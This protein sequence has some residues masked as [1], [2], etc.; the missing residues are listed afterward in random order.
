M[1]ATVYKQQHNSRSQTR[2]I[3][4][5]MREFERQRTMYA[6]SRAVRENTGNEG[7]TSG[8]HQS[9]QPVQTVQYTQLFRYGRC[10][11]GHGPS[12]SVV[13]MRSHNSIPS[14]DGSMKA[15]ESLESKFR[16][17]HT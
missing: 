13:R 3:Q 15:G 1:L 2:G 12:P 9:S 11:D 6:E 4:D 8:A 14:W 7:P 16:M 17:F 10:M 5:T